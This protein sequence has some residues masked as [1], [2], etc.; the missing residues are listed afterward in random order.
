M[1]HKISLHDL[2]VLAAAGHPSA[3]F[4]FLERA[5]YARS[6]TA[7]EQRLFIQLLGFARSLQIENPLFELLYHQLLHLYVL[8]GSRLNLLKTID[9]RLRGLA[10]G[11][12]ALLLIS[13]VSGIGKTSLATAFQERA[14]GLGASFIQVHCFEQEAGAFAVW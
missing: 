13:G 9:R 3:N 10:D 2:I 4:D 12:D 7:A 11:Q 8:N 5:V 14:C 6:L 1:T